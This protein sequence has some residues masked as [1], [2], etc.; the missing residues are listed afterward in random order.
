MDNDFSGVLGSYSQSLGGS[1]NM[2][3]QNENMK[4]S[5]FYKSS[6]EN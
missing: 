1:R 5:S 2:H 4:Q 6:K 3:L